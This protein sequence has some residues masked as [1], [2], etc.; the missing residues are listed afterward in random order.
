MTED[1]D[2]TRRKY[3]GRHSSVA[4]V[5]D[6]KHWIRC[7]DL[8]DLLEC[9]QALFQVHCDEDREL[10]N[11]RLAEMV[12]RMRAINGTDSATVK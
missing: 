4:I 2:L 11:Q 8:K 1:D 12:S 6:N 10:Q 3:M 7:R 5:I 9:A